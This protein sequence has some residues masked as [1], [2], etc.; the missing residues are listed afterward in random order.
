MA[1][2][3]IDGPRELRALIDGTRRRWVRMV[4]LRTA[5]RGMGAAA[6]PML[7]AAAA[8]TLTG[9]DGLS[10][11]ILV[12]T[13]VIAAA[14]AAALP[15]FQVERRLD[16]RRVARFV[17]ERSRTL[18]GDRAL[19]D[20]LVSALD[21]SDRAEHPERAAFLPLLLQDAVRRLR[22]IDPTEIVTQQS[23][24]GAAARA[25]AG[26]AVLVLALAVSSPTLERAV[27]TARLRFFP[28]SVR[29]EVG[30][31]NVRVPAGT[32]LRIRAALHGSAGSLKRFTPSL[33][34]AAGD[35]RRTVDLTPAADAFEIVI[36]SVDRTFTYAVAAGS[37]R[38]EDYTV[39]AVFPPRVERIDLH[40]V[41]PSFAG[42]T[43]R[44]ERDGGDIYAPA[45]TKVRLRIHTDKPVAQAE[46]ALGGAAAVPTRA[47]APR[48]VEADLVLSRDD[49]YRVRLSDLDGL[50]STGDTEYFIRLMDDRPPDVRILRP[51][52]DQQITPLE[53][54]AIEAR[55]DDDYGIAAF[56]LVYA[57]GGG[58]E[59]IVPFERVSGSSVQKI[60]MRLLPAEDL[61]VKPGDVI[62]YYARAR[63][64][65]RG[66]RS[67][68]ATSDI[69]F[70]EVAPFNEEF[71]AAQ[72]QTSA[73]GAADAQIESLVQ[74]QKAIIASTWNVERRSQG[75]RSTEDVKAIAQAQAELKS[76]VEQMTSGRARR[77]GRLPQRADSGEAQ[78]PRRAEV[79]PLGAAV[80]AMAK[81]EETLAAERT[82]EALPHE[83]AAL[84]G[85]L[86]AQSEV[87]RRMVSQQA[88][89]TGSGGSN[90]SGQD[91]SALFDKE[92]Q[93]QQRTNYE[94]QSAVE[95]RPDQRQSS[96]SALD[97]IRDLARRQE[98]LSRRQRELSEAGLT[99]E[100]LKRQLEKLTREQTDLREQ[101][102]D[103][104]RRLGP[105][106]QSQRGQRGQLPEPAS[107][108]PRGDGGQRGRSGGDLRE[109]SEQMRTAAGQLRRDDPSAAAQ[110]GQR[111]AEQLR[112]LEERMRG[113]AP[114]ASQRAGSDV[115]LEAQQIASEQR[116][117]SAEAERLD[118][119]T[120]PAAAAARRR[121][122][123]EKERLAG[124]VDELQR[125]AQ[126]LAGGKLPQA[127]KGVMNDAARA[128]E[129]E[130]IAQRM[131]DTAKKMRDTAAAPAAGAA[132]AEM[133]LARALERVADGLDQAAPPETRALSGQLDQTRAI[134]DRL[135]RLEQQMRDAEGRASG[136]RADRPPDDQPGR[137]QTT[138]QQGA[139]SG[140]GGSAGDGS[141]RSDLQ[142][143]QEAYQRELQRSRDALARLGQEEPSGDAGGST[144]EHHEFSRSAPGTEAFKQDRSGWELLRKD[145]DLALEKYEA[146]VSARLAKGR[147]EDRLSAGGSQRVPDRYG[148]RIAKYFESL[149]K[150]K[151]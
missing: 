25:A 68:R 126:Q 113:N 111:A 110:S 42:L 34:V 129:A 52:A 31:G 65:G 61:G 101:A 19:D 51:S 146:A 130:R 106:S 32:P 55:A 23:M 54:V 150:E 13:A 71:V 57:V 124:R 22:A 24:R 104:S 119:S 5:G 9:A 30:P 133:D 107:G 149:A 10:L 20:V 56:D 37:A 69:F 121:L 97:R 53:E 8:A 142:R 112:R 38:S 43:P 74:A 26:A 108:Q 72:S 70:L 78:R 118:N 90:R 83:M 1:S 15:I 137:G 36:P 89:G 145:L 41:Y 86:Q 128:L 18:S 85:L 40:Y 125:S 122:A 147:A 59:R 79:D 136:A 80:E 33:V 58:P 28:G 50:H 2:S 114:G 151:K 123:D 117:I 46:L 141:P 73:A 64:V 29:L 39:T 99:A 144:P 127:E 67:T 138:Q 16:D 49:S 140:R 14:V 84:N 77:P 143:L 100:E 132:A 109:A 27:E 120:G 103:L 48:T 45:G 76:R 98:D 11:V 60:G 63:D 134:R 91:L 4:A 35:Q 47:V 93:R 6:V 75:G 82:R 135:Q 148:R 12:G 17:E 139:G 87:R 81:A 21:A 44:D 102:E 131:R 94:T 115:Q 62:T 116:R 105:Q 66:K 92:L 96:D 3:R 95:T 88:S 7:A